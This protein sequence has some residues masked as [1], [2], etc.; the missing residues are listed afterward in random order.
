MFRNVI[1]WIWNFVISNGV[2]DFNVLMGDRVFG[3][4]K[5]I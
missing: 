2:C 4:E 1:D 5:I 3:E